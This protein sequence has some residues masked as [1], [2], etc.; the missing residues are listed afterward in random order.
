MVL[1]RKLDIIVIDDDEV[2]RYALKRALSN[3]NIR[4]DLTECSDA[5]SAMAELS[6]SKFDCVFLDYLLPGADGLSL[7]QEMKQAGITAPIIVITSQ[8]DEQVAVKMMKAGASDYIVKTYINAQ[9]IEQVL[10]HALRLYEMEKMRAET[11]KALR[12]SEARLAEAQRIAAIGN[13]EFDLIT[14]GMFWSDEVYRIYGLSKDEPAGEQLMK[15]IHP[16][17]M[18]VIDNTLRKAYNGEPATGDFRIVLNDG[19]MKYIHIQS[20]PQ[21]HDGKLVKLTGTVQ[22]ITA[23]KLVERELTEAKKKAEESTIIKERFLANMSHEIRTPMNAI[24]GFAKLLLQTPLNSEQRSFIEAI[25]ISGEKLL[26]IINDI[27]DYSKIEA[28]KLV[29]EKTTMDPAQVAR[30]VAQLLAIKAN[31]KGLDLSVTVDEKLPAALIGDPVRLSQV[32]TNLA[33]NAIKFT[34]KGYV[35]I[36]IKVAEESGTFHVLDFSVEDS[37][38][39]IE[40]DKLDH[41]FEGFAQAASDT[42]RKFGGTGLGLTIARN[43]VEIQGG[44]ISVKSI[45]GSGTTFTARIPFERSQDN[46]APAVA[47]SIARKDTRLDGVRVLLAED[48][49]LNSF[50]A[51]T[52]LQKSGC[53]TMLA[54]NGVE[55]IG[56]LKQHQFDVVLMDIQ[57]PEMDGYTATRF[58]RTQLDEPL[59]SIPIIAMTAHALHDEQA[60]CINLGMNDYISKPFDPEALRAKIRALAEGSEASHM[61][62]LL[63]EK[64]AAV[65]GINLG[66]A[67]LALSHDEEVLMQVLRMF[68]ETVPQQLDE[69]MAAAE[70]NNIPLLKNL[71]H[72]MRPGFGFIGAQALHEGL[73]ELEENVEHY[74]DIPKEA[75]NLL[76]ARGRNVLELLSTEL[77]L[78]EN[79]QR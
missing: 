72:K 41:V 32:L 3:T 48:N 70:N 50:L 73:R 31:E 22:D 71:A 29:I 27:L 24:T 44:T 17:D 15:F 19:R 1:K 13:W 12:L 42:S 7:L 52:I 2:D 74:V 39:G 69:M 54:K 37:G 68:L 34:E 46:T 9:S 43:I 26:V 40:E 10:I 47:P 4:Y 45:P 8:G 18:F 11:E 78:M 23:R 5:G 51:I 6:S 14:S 20:R 61:I 62:N 59:R 63:H 21:Y 60:K 57:M 36:S 35:K 67:R 56:L 77:R 58:I 65:E 33:G 30:D 38:I 76:Y 66:Q 64:S 16:D 49:E 53:Q 28:G 79:G 75:V 55:A 25:D